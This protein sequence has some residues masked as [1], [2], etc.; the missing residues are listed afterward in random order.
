MAEEKK[1]DKMREIRIEK[2]VVNI[3]IGDAGDRLTRASRVLKELTD[4]EPCYSVARLTV[5]TFGIRR[6]ERIS[7][8]VTVRGPRAEAILQRGL[9]VKE[10]ELKQ[11]NFSDTG[12]FG[13]GIDE[14]IDLGLKYDPSVGIYGMDFYIVLSRPG[15]RVA[16]R[17]RGRARVGKTHKISKEE[18]INWFK[19]KF[20]GTVSNREAEE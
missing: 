18:A 1:S 20:N 6:N 5:R 3:C 2:L 9:A 13:F 17:K 14:H 10:F 15:F 16:R 11:K 19:T 4:Q 7:T 12:N 8:H